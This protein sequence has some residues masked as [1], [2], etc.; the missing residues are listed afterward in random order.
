[1][2]NIE[3]FTTCPRCRDFR[4][5][6]R[7]VCLNEDCGLLLRHCLQKNPLSPEYSFRTKKYFIIVYLDTTSIFTRE[8]K[9]LKSIPIK[10]NYIVDDNQIDN[11]I[12]LA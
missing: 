10:I 6:I 1:M 11:Y 8:C 2:I 3:S 9:F 4:D 12:L 7:T 5:I